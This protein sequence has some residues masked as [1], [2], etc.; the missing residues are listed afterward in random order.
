MVDFA[1]FQVGGVV[2]PLTSSLTNS[3]LQDADPSLYYAGQYFSSVINTYVWPRMQAIANAL[4]VITPLQTSAIRTYVP[5][6]PMPFLQEMQD[7][8]PLLA[9]YRKTEKYGYKSYAWHHDLQEWGV[10]YILPPLSPGQAERVMPLLRSVAM[11]LRDR[12]ENTFDPAF[13]SGQSPWALAGLEEIELTE[14]AYGFASV[15]NTNLVFP[16]YQGKLLVKERAMEVA[17]AFDGVFGGL[18]A[19]IGIASSTAPTVTDVSDVNWTAYTSTGIASISTVLAVYTA[20]AGITAGVDAA[21][22]GAWSPAAGTTIALSPNGPS[23]QPGLVQRAITLPNGT[24]KPVVRFD[25]TAS[26]LAGAA[27]ALAND[28]GKTFIAL[29]RLSDNVSRSTIFG[30]AQASDVG[31]TA[32]AIEANTSGTSGGKLGVMAAGSYYDAS[33]PASSGWHVA[34]LTVSSSSGAEAGTIS[35]S[36]DSGPA[37]LTKVSGSGT[38]ASLA[39]SNQLIVGGLIS[40]ISTTAAHCDIGVLISAS[41]VLSATNIAACVTY[42]RQWAGMQ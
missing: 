33:I 4:P 14:G 36:I 9:V 39:S 29:Y 26:Q 25:G 2:Y 18:D 35:L 10:S 5:Y 28:S 13:M 6:D 41:S 7:V 1:T 24:Q 38:W 42:C 3:S 32:L 19:E 16:G 15:P 22:V 40:A 27:T 31:A 23:N 12:I 21:H 11:T 20:D 17:A 30:Q 34:V 8:F 37:V